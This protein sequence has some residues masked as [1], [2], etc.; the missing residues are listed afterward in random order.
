MLVYRTSFRSHVNL[1][2]DFYIRANLTTKSIML[3]FGCHDDSRNLATFKHAF[4]LAI[5]NS[6]VVF[7]VNKQYLDESMHLIQ[8]H[9]TMCTT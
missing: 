8:N 7:P 3:E 9:D 6:L 4:S 2:T 1:S 5:V